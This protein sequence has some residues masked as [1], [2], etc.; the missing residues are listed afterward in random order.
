MIITQQ[1][2]KL[3]PFMK[4]EAPLTYAQ[5]DRILSHMNPAHIYETLIFFTVCRDRPVL[6][7]M[8]QLTYSDSISV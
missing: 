3:R 8:S 7:Q 6:R 1:I 2:E 4:S 5:I